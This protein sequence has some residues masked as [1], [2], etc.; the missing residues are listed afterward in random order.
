MGEEETEENHGNQTAGIF[1]GGG[2]VWE[3]EPRGRK[4]AQE[5]AEICWRS[6]RSVQKQE[7]RRQ[8]GWK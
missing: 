7:K 2:G 3:P 1:C 4:H 5:V 8:G 6:E